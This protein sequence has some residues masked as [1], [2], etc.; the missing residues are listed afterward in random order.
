MIKSERTQNKIVT[1]GF[2]IINS[3]LVDLKNQIHFVNEEDL[4]L[5][6]KDLIDEIEPSARDSRSLY[7]K[8]GPVVA[9][10]DFHGRDL[11]SSHGRCRRCGPQTI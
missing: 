8:A 11:G 7:N 4:N 6:R 9:R 3:L 2:I 1:I 10:T 5:R